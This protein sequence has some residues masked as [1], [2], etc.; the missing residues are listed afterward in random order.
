MPKHQCGLISRYFF[1]FS[2][3]VDWI[4][5]TADSVRPFEI[6]SALTLM[7]FSTIFIIGGVSISLEYP[8]RGFAVASSIW[9]WVGMFVLG[10]CQWM[11]LKRTSIRSDRRSAILL[12]LSSV[13]YLVLVGLFSSDYPPLSTAVPIYFI[14]AVMCMFGS[15]KRMA[16]VKQVSDE[17]ANEE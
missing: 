3:L 4:F 11:A 1:K 7:S 15:V 6:I 14:N 5:P 8:Y 13:V 10:A 16:I 17:I 2:V 9:W 12:A